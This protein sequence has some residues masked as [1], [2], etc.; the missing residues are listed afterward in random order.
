MVNGS[1]TNMA[2]PPEATALTRIT[3]SETPKAMSAAFLRPSPSEN[4]SEKIC[5]FHEVVNSAPYD[6][7]QHDER[8][9]RGEQE[10]RRIFP[11]AMIVGARHLSSY[12]PPDSALSRS[13]L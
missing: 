12:S 10:P 5:I 8:D 11:I 4:G 13:P 6:R 1:S 9:R 7:D 3:A 2:S